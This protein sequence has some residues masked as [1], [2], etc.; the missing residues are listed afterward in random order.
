[1]GCK[2]WY[3]D[4]VLYQ[5]YFWKYAKETEFYDEILKIKS[6]YTEEQ[7]FKDREAENNLRLLAE[8]ENSCVGDD[9]LSQKMIDEN[10]NKIEKSKERLEILEKIIFIFS[11]ISSYSK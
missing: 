5:E 9:R 1:M 8:K 6:E 10:L 2:P 4:D 11:K 7:K 3:F